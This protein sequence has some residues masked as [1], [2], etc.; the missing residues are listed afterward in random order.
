MASRKKFKRMRVQHRCC[1]CN[2]RVFPF[3][4]QDVRTESPWRDPTDRQ[5]LLSTSNADP[6]NRTAWCWACDTWV[7]CVRLVEHEIL[8]MYLNRKG[9]VVRPASAARARKKVK[10][11]ARR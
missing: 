8:Q 2:S 6:D 4:S 3:D 5:I 11:T 10:A 9:V 1:V 7:S